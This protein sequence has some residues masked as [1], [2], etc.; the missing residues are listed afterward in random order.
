[1]NLPEGGTGPGRRSDTSPLRG[2]EPKV[3]L[4]A[5]GAGKTL[6]DLNSSAATSWLCVLGECIHSVG[7]NLFLGPMGDSEV[8][9]IPLTT[10]VQ[11]TAPSWPWGELRQAWEARGPLLRTLALMT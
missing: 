7:L 11:L 2:P 9:G 5:Q 3:H 4:G 1:M 8:V 6:L 10:R